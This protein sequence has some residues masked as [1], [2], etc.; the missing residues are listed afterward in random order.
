MP[1]IRRRLRRAP[2]TGT[3]YRRSDWERRRKPWVAEWNAGL[4]Y[5]GVRDR[6]HIGDYETEKDAIDAVDTYRLTLG[7]GADIPR[8][9]TYGEIWDAVCAK[10]EEDGNPINRNY[11]S[12]WRHHIGPI[13]RNVAIEDGDADRLQRCVDNSGLSGGAQQRIKTIYRWIYDWA[14]MH[15]LCQTDLSRFVRIAAKPISTLHKPFTT[16]ELRALWAHTDIEYVQVV[17]IAIYTGMRPTE[18]ATVKTEDV[19]IMQRY[20]VGGMKTAAGRNR[21][22]PIARC[23]L[24]FVQHF[25]NTARFQRFPY[26]LMP[27]LSKGLYSRGGHV[28]MARIYREYLPQIGIDGHHGHDSR[29]TFASLA[30]NYEINETTKKRILGHSRGKDVTQDVYTHKTAMQLIAAVD[31]LPWGA[32]MESFPGEND[33]LRGCLVD[34]SEQK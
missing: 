14:I 9:A 24:P 10:H 20:M 33:F 2:G 19:H 3:V 21:T 23:I 5:G 22:I 11:I 6:I 29:H 1:K 16:K 25:T 26:F 27:D 30:D 18:L 15:N 4:K 28:D 17:L 13:I 7:K 8:K 34:V 31:T 32:E 12:T